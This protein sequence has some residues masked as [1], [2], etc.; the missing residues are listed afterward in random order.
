MDAVSTIQSLC[1]LA[2]TIITW[3]DQMKDK[4][5]TLSQISKT[6]GTIHSILVSFQQNTANFDLE[7]SLLNALIGLGDILSRTREH[8]AAFRKARR[9][10]SIDTVL[11]FLVPARVSQQLIRDEEQLAHQLTIILF[12]FSSTSFIRDSFLSAVKNEDAVSFRAIRNE[13]VF[14]FWRDYLGAKVLYARRDRFLEALTYRFGNWLSEAARRRLFMR[15]DEFR[16]GGVDASTLERFVGANSLQ[17]AVEKFQIFESTVSIPK[18]W[19]TD[20]RL[21]LLV[22][23]DDQ[24]DNNVEHVRFAEELGV[25]VV[26]FPSTALV[27]AW[28]EDNEGRHTSDVNNIYINN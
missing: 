7:H 1:S 18:P 19:K 26:Q 6:V 27:K 9:S 28:I 8:I 15:L 10:A 5:E 2:V 25:H 14:E 16:I 3:I 17:Q 11:D 24:P 4:K 13:D 23:I 12:S 22:W 20:P 21:P